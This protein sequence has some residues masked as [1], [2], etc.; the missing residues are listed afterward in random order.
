M[1]ST[2]RLAASDRLRAGFPSFIN[3][4]YD[5]W[6]ILWVR[7]PVVI[8]S[9][10][11]AIG[12]MT[13]TNEPLPAVER[14]TFDSFTLDSI[15]RAIPCECFV[16]DTTISMYYLIRDIAALS[17]APYVYTQIVSGS[18]NPL[19]YLVYWNVYGFFMWCL[20]VIGHDCGHSSFSEYGL[21]NDICGHVAHAPLMVP[22]YPWAMS[23]RRHHM[24][25]NHQ[26]RDA[27]HP[28]FTS[29]AWARLPTITKMMSL[30]MITPFIG[31]AMYLYMGVFDGSHIFPF[32]KLFNGASWRTRAKCVLSTAIVAAY[33]YCIGILCE[34]SAARIALS[35]GG[36][37]AVFGFWLFMVTYLQHH[38]VGTRVYSDE[39]WAFLKG[40]LETI[41]RTYGYGIDRLHHN[42]SDGHV[43][44]HLFFSQIPHYRLS[45]V[46]PLARRHPRARCTYPCTSS[47]PMRPTG[48]GGSCAHIAMRRR[49]QTREP[50]PRRFLHRHLLAHVLQLQL[51]W[52]EVGQVDVATTTPRRSGWWRSSVPKPWR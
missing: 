51:H 43:I 41:D 32:S 2:G 34:W 27:S 45:Q 9:C 1:S 44:H 5:L 33:A 50:R 21:L 40:G 24:F 7:P 52:L 25:H 23:H 14:V 35:Y 15:R 18:L 37:Y 46:P 19:V 22:Y 16:K 29:H 36:C 11:P 30:S 28:W 17:T 39:D 42:I 48:H 26:K 4:S 3:T 12:S 38:D 47:L 31:F 8:D 10:R 6:K 20:F 49:I 13:C